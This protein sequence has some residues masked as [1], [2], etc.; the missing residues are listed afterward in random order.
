MVRSWCCSGRRGLSPK[1][2]LA[3]AKTSRTTQIERPADEENSDGEVEEVKRAGVLE[4]QRILEELDD[5]DEQD[6]LGDAILQV[7]QARHL[8][9]PRHGPGGVLD[10]SDLVDEQ[11]VQ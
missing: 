6:Q 5:E 1:S 11:L 3:P 10:R 7:V 2:V 4:L 9:Q 8:D